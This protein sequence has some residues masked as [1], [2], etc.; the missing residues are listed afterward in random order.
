MKKLI[1]ISANIQ[2]L[3]FKTCD[4]MSFFIDVANDKIYTI[5]RRE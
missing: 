5:P 2:S 1:Q 3:I 4:R